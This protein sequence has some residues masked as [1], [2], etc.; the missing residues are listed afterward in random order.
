MLVTPDS[1][2]VTDDTDQPLGQ[3]GHRPLAARVGRGRGRHVVAVAERAVRAGPGDHHR[4]PGD[5]FTDVRR[6]VGISVEEHGVADGAPDHRGVVG[7]GVVRGVGIGT[8]RAV[9]A[10][11]NDVVQMIGIDREIDSHREGHRTARADASDPTSYVHVVA[12]QVQPSDEE[13]ATNVESLGM[14]SV[15]VTPVAPIGPWL[16]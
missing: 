7:A 9:V 13:P 8:V 14:V 12:P 3:T 11:D 1:G 5:A 10:D 15:S 16:V 2:E 6:A 4:G